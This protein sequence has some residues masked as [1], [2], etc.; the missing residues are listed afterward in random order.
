MDFNY[1]FWYNEEMNNPIFEIEVVI[2]D[3]YGGFSFDTEM[4]LWLMENKGWVIEKSYEKK[5]YPLNCLIESGL[6]YFYTPHRESIALR[7]HPDL[8]ECVK[9]LKKFHEN[10]S[11]QQKRE[12][13]IHSLAIKKVSINLEIDEYHDGKERVIVKSDDC[14]W[15]GSMIYDKLFNR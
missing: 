9:T 3:D 2:N 14:E 8:I 11:Y 1:Y 15:T 7:T 6:D 10:D 5:D 13:H 12:G 4:A